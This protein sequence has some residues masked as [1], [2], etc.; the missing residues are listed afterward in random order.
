MRPTTLT[1]ECAAVRVPPPVHRLGW[2][3]GWSLA[4][5]GLA[6]LYAPVVVRLAAQ[7][8]SDANFSYAFLVP[9]FCAWLVWRRRRVL[10]VL[11]L[12]PAGIGWVWMFAALSMLLTGRLASELF[13]T[14]LSLVVMIGGLLLAL[15]GRAWLRALAFPLGFLIL[16]IPIP[17]LIFNLITLPMQGWATRLGVGLVSWTGLPILREGNLIVLPAAVLDVVAA[18]SGI[19]SLLA[20]V[21]LAAGYGYLTEPRWLRRLILVAAMLPLAV[22]SNAIRIALTVVLTFRFGTTASEGVWHFLTGLQ[23]F[24]VALAGLVTL[25]WALQKWHGPYPMERRT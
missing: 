3:L 18:C 8:W 1:S 17:T 13:L 15:G 9:P 6:L 14:R 24:L 2:M 21:A 12:K 11:M 5:L 10:L 20:L 16:M 7:W 25:Q 4:A 19:R 23:V 22:I